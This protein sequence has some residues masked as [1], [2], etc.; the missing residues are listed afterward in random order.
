MRLTVRYGCGWH[1]PSDF[2]RYSRRFWRLR[3]FN[4]WDTKTTVG[5][6]IPF[7]FL[8]VIYER[9]GMAAFKDM[10]FSFAFYA[11]DLFTDAICVS[12]WIGSHSFNGADA[13]AGK[14]Y[15]RCAR[16][17]R[18]PKRRYRN[19]WA[20]RPSAR[21]ACGSASRRNGRSI[22]AYLYGNTWDPGQGYGGAHCSRRLLLSSRG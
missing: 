18:D 21:K 3:K 14:L 16:V 20:W 4:R 22:N 7:F 19:F 5:F 13:G 11:Y 10:A 15:T 6:R 17:F 8:E 12:L 1:A 2:Y 9:S